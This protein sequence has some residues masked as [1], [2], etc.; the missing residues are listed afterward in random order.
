[1]RFN[2]NQF[3]QV[4]DEKTLRRGLNYYLNGKVSLIGVNS[5]NEFHFVSDGASLF[6]TRK[7]NSIV[8][9]QCACRREPCAHLASALFW[10]QQETLGITA[11]SRR[12]KKKHALPAT[13][14]ARKKDL[15]LAQRRVFSEL[16]NASGRRLSD[17]DI[18]AFLEKIKER[19][20][21][22]GI[23][24]KFAL[25]L[26][27]V[28]ELG[29]LKA[30]YHTGSLKLE[31]I[32]QRAFRTVDQKFK[33]G[34][35]DSMSA[36]LWRAGQR[37]L[38]N[39]YLYSNGTAYFLLSRWMI[40]GDPNMASALFAK[41]VKKRP[42]LIAEAIN[43]AQIMKYQLAMAF[44]NG[45]RGD[46]SAPAVKQSDEYAI[47][48]S[49]IAFLSGDQERGFGILESWFKKCAVNGFPSGLCE[50]IILKAREIMNTDGERKYLE[51]KM[52]GGIYI[53][54][55][56]F[57]RWKGLLNDRQSG[58]EISRLVQKL[59][60]RAQPFSED[61]VFFLLMESGRLEELFGMLRKRKGVFRM[62][63]QLALKK[64][65][66]TGDL[67]EGEYAVQLLDALSRPVTLLHQKKIME[68]ADEYLSR[69]NPQKKLEIIA[70]VYE[71][72]RGKQ[73]GS[74]LAERYQ[75]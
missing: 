9:W 53:A 38:N 42:R 23:E 4:L 2:I 72:W 18:T 48:A 26:V 24:E 25:Q 34:L 73:F 30:K 50:H 61:K 70:R 65:G 47:A 37:A 14:P 74:W 11:K 56:D 43:Y 21:Q 71:D 6:V 20:S 31:K 64:S 29:L 22:P 3:E 36:N 5:A 12:R 52:I 33:T 49:D 59:R 44:G 75:F 35:S 69:L 46:G 27:V 45:F 55:Q 7:G 28:T 17:N 39:P 62:F 51:A 58:S 60:S 16:L 15:Y 8:S 13:K 1:M 57:S 40:T 67:I 66:L 10:W 32:L 68:T 19:L 54:P 41:L 63:H